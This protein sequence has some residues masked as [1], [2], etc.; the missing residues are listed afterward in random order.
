MVE[1]RQMV[2]VVGG[3]ARPRPLGA[4]GAWLALLLLA[5]PR[6]AA[7]AP[8]PAAATPAGPGAAA[9]QQRLE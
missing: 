8:G 2:Q 6:R 3:G 7:P 5:P 4:D 9:L 1:M